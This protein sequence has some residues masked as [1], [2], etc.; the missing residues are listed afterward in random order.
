M[1]HSMDIAPKPHMPEQAVT[2]L[3]QALRS[4]SCYLEHG[5]GGSTVLADT[6]G[7]PTTI[8]VES[9]KEWLGRLQK[10]IVS[11]P[12]KLRV[13]LHADI[14]PTGEWGHPVDEGRWR[15]WHRYPL[16]GWTECAARGLSPDLILI[17][18]RFRVACFYAALIFGQPGAVILFDDYADRP[19]YHEVERLVRPAH[20]HDRMAEFVI[21]EGLDNTSIWL[22]FTDAVTDRR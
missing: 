15:Q 16:M 20:M 19:F 22:A 18:G 13:F 12:E 2:R 5:S 21:P 4:A 8:S 17:D 7:T 1:A 14:G 10:Q 6:I 3:E 11:G 9:D